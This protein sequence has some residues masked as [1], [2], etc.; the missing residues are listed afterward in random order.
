M[1]E[2]YLCVVQNT[3]DVD[4]LKL[5]YL[6][7]MSCYITQPKINNFS[8][9]IDKE[10]FKLVEDKHHKVFDTIIMI[11]NDDAIDSKIKQQNEA[12]VFDAS[13]YK[14]TIKTEADMLFSS[15]YS[16]YWDVCNP[17][18]MVFTQQ[19]Y[20]YRNQLINNR[21]Q[22]QLFDQ[23]KLPNIYSGWTYF[24]FDKEC[25]TFYDT[26]KLIVKD[27]AWYRD[28]YLINCRYDTPRTDELYAIAA[29]ILNTTLIDTKF[30]F[31]HMKS[32]LLGLSKQVD[33]TKIL[34]FE[35]HNDFTPVVGFVR[36]SKP[37]H[38][39][40]KTFVTNEMIEKYEQRYNDVLQQRMVG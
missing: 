1:N 12:K 30:G 2:G 8:I 31:V 32:E 17:L 11:E 18:N 21:S 7:A 39:Q 26:I 19:V 25:K 23:N 22:R 36:Q 35:L 40:V 6:Q 10:T 33:W 27:W 14:R 15:D 37:L 16:W 38:Y 9:L 34:K 4:Y 13:P 5:A 20:T 3:A 28:Q 29:K 24:T